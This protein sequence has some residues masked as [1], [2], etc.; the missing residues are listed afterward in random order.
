[1][2]NDEP[3]GGRRMMVPVLDV[4]TDAAVA[5]IDELRAEARAAALRGAARKARRAH[6]RTAR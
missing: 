6:P 5:H 1:M 3:E 4:T 2:N